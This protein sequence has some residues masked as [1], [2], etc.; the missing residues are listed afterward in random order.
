MKGDNLDS[1]MNSLIK[2]KGFTKNHRP[3]FKLFAYI[4]IIILF[5]RFH[6]YDRDVLTKRVILVGFSEEDNY[7]EEQMADIYLYFSKRERGCSEDVGKGAF[8]RG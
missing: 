1:S 3:V 5:S 8:D 4:K 2:K 6:A 7:G